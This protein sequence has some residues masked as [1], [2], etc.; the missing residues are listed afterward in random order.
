MTSNKIVSSKVVPDLRKPIKKT[1][2]FFLK[3]KL[4]LDHPLKL[5]LLKNLIFLLGL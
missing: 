4:V 3:E 1:G 5:G 2:F